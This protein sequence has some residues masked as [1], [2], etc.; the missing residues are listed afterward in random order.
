[1][2]DIQIKARTTE[3]QT[4]EVFVDVNDLII[5]LMLEKENVSN[6]AAREAMQKMIDKLI[7]IRKLGHQRSNQD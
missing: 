3:A 7:E 5:D 4:R 6:Q 1:M 2:T